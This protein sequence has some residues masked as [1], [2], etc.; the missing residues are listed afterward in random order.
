MISDTS[1]LNSLRYETSEI[2]GHTVVVGRKTVKSTKNTMCDTYAL[3]SQRYK[4][5][6]ILSDTVV[7]NRITVKSAKNTI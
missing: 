4:I 1:A 2:L 6:D 7:N 3:M 5:S